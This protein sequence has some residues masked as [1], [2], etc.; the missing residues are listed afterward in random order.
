ML[1]FNERVFAPELMDNPDVDRS[2]LWKNLREL[3][4]ANS[5]F[6]GNAIIRKGI[7]KLLVKGHIYTVA[8]LGCG[9]GGTLKHLAKWARSKKLKVR[10]IGVDSNPQAIEFLKKHCI[11]YPEITGIVKDYNEF[12]KTS[13]VADIYLCSLFCH[14]LGNESLV[15]LFRELKKAK[16]GFVISDLQRSAMAYYG[17]WLFTRLFRGTVLSKNDGPLSVRK[18]FKKKELEQLL[19]EAGC[20]VVEL[21]NILFFR[22]RAVV[23][24][25]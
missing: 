3:N 21:R 23:T 22:I 19:W 2:V 14:H 18:A 16:I 17:I 1:K 12:L 25:N 5:L 6:R 8:D 7:K 9:G 13:P 20:H 24:N 11:S 10:F 15:N 4:I